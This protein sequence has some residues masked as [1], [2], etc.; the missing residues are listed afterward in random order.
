MLPF[1]LDESL[2]R[3]LSSYAFDHAA[4]ATAS[5]GVAVAVAVERELVDGV[6]ERC[7]AEGLD[8]RLVTTVPAALA[9]TQV[10]GVEPIPVEG[11]ESSQADVTVEISRN[12]ESESTV[13]ES[14][15]VQVGNAETITVPAGEFEAFRVIWNIRNNSNWS[16]WSNRSYWPSR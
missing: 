13:D 7:R 8:V 3:P 16:Y 10:G 15:Q 9:Q 12:G 5:G 4:A 11:G 14:H 1:E 6:V 2:A